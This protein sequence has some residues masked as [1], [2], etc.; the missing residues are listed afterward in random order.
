[1]VLGKVPQLHICVTVVVV[2]GVLGVTIVRGEVLVT[3]VDDREG[4]DVESRSRG[5]VT[6]TA[7]RYPL[8]LLLRAL[9]VHA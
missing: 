3:L 2:F 8:P 9:G 1:M 6:A 7:R 5:M 4:L